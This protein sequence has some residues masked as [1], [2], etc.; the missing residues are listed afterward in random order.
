MPLF[1]THQGF[2]YPIGTA[3]TIGRVPCLAVSAAHNIRET[4]RHEKRLSHLLTT[5]TLP[6][7]VELKEAGVSLLYNRIEEDGSRGRLSIWPLETIEG[8]P[9]TDIVIG[10]PQFQ[11]QF[12]T[13]VNRLS[14]DVPAI[15]ST[16]WS[17]GYTAMQ[18]D[19]ISLSDL[20]SGA[21]DLVR[22]Y[23]HKLIVVEGTVRRFFTQRFAAGYVEGPCFAFDA[24]ID[25]GQ[26]GGPVMTTDGVI[27][28]VNTAA[29]SRFFDTPMS[30]AS[31]LYPMLFQNLRFGAKMGPV[32]MNASRR[33]FDLVGEGRIPTDGSETEIA[34][35]HDP[36][37]GRFGVS[38]R[39]PVAM[40][41][42]VHDDFRAFQEGKRATSQ[43]K[44][45]FRLR[46]IEES[47]ASGD[48]A[49]S[50]DSKPSSEQ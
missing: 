13:L 41:E 29:A 49:H 7:S 16:V 48:S 26:S 37:T 46:R 15:G 14:F 20:R 25:H 18:P 36:E 30:L 1:I 8:A 4:W 45:V 12:P 22:D 47:D 40:V 5:D 2:L 39:F 31:P 27:V 3:F 23:S 33:M 19:R 17:I 44:P 34:L 6:P 38:P 24:E 10:Y 28:G 35:T 9:P 11:T 32:T 21:F 43:T 50:S 42:F